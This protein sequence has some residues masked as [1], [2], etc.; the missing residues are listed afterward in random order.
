MFQSYFINDTDLLAQDN[1]YDTKV[2][3]NSGNGMA[4]WTNVDQL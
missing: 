3:I 1:A 4:T 2:P